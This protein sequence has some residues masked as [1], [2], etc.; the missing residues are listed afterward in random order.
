MSA[1]LTIEQRRA[2]GDA[3]RA[4]FAASHPREHGESAMSHAARALAWLVT[5]E[6][7]QAFASAFGLAAPT[8]GLTGLHGGSVFDSPLATP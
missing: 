4:T 6:G 2:A 7:K 5:P 3:Y 8:P 1:H